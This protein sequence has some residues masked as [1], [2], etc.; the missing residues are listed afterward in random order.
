MKLGSVINC[1]ALS[2]LSVPDGLPLDIQKPS[3]IKREHLMTER[4]SVKV[5]VKA[6]YTTKELIK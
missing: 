5:L 4:S 2:T 3:L 1:T 6:I